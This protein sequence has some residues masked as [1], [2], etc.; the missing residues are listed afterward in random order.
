MGVDDAQAPDL[1]KEAAPDP[2]KEETRAEGPPTGCYRAESKV[3]QTQRVRRPAA[4]AAAAT[5]EAT[6]KRRKYLRRRPIHE[7]ERGKRAIA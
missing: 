7:K 3:G 5:E 4:G 1:P 6:R 2:S